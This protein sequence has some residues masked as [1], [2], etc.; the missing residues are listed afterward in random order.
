MAPDQPARRR[1]TMRRIRSSL[2]LALSVAALGSIGAQPVLAEGSTVTVSGATVG[3]STI[4]VTGNVAYGTDATEETVLGTD[5]SGDTPVPGMDLTGISVRPNISGRQLIWKLSIANGLPAPIDGPP[6]VGTAYMVPIMVDGDDKWRWLAAGTTG[7]AW[8]NSAKWTGLCHNELAD[9]TQGGWSCPGTLAGANTYT[10]AGSI[11]QAGVTWTQP[12]TQMKPPIKFGSTL[13]P[14]SILCGRP[15]SFAFPPGF[16]L[17]G[18]HQIDALDL[19]EGYKVPGE[20]KLA[21]TPAGVVPSEAAFSSTAAFSHTAS[22]FAGSVARP[23]TP[24]AYTVWARTCFGKT[25]ALTCVL[26][27]QNVTV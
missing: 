3:A 1:N 20:V 16:A 8:A 14:S 4:S 23:A 15:C 27:S 12:F 25:E 24:G 5:P 17:G 2:V 9:G 26:G 11:T 13:E 21:I 7:S 10:Y 22:T 6:P 19:M 18:L